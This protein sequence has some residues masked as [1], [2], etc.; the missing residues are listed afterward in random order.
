MFLGYLATI[1]LAKHLFYAFAHV[2]DMLLP[3][4]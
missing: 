4:I 1:K 2:I 3:I